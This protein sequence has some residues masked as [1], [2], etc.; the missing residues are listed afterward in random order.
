LKFKD[1]KMDEAEKLYN[2]AVLKI[3]EVRDKI[4]ISQKQN[5]INLETSCLLNLSNIRAGNNDFTGLLNLSKEVVMLNP[6][7]G[8]GFYR[9]AQA[10]FGLEKYEAAFEKIKQ[11]QK[12][13]N[14]SESM[15][16]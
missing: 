13:S 1:K 5:L 7:S 4:P 12:Y 16:S 2:E 8:K 15:L 11:A 14:F 3:E 9:Y 10:L 6:Q